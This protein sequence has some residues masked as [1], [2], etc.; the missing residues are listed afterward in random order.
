MLNTLIINGYDGREHKSLDQVRRP[1]RQSK[2]FS[3]L[4]LLGIVK[5]Y[6]MNVL[7][8]LLFL[9]VLRGRISK[10]CEEFIVD[11]LV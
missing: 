8:V 4:H 7:L 5:H 11:P 10:I 9:G 1:T 2:Q 3:V 6:P